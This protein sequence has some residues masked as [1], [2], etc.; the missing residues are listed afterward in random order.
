MT[1]KARSSASHGP[2]EP[3]DAALLA[4]VAAGDL[5]ALGA[6]FDRHVGP[7]R[8]VLLRLGARPADVDDLTQATFLDVV[9]A[10]ASYDGRPSAR[11]WLVGLAVIQVRRRR[12]SLARLAGWMSAWAR[13]PA[14]HVETPEHLAER[15]ELAARARTALGGLSQKKREVFVLVALEGLSGPEVAE[16]LG[17]PVATVWTRLHHARTE[18][19][20]SLGEE[21]R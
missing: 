11:S 2:A 3:T 7:V 21:D 6:L 13:E 8:R 14:P 16:L 1:P 10:A 4:E 18:L 9:H 19:R 12:R 5:G 20:A 17:I 15:Q